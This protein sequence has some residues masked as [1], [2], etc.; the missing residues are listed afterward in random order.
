MDLTATRRY[1]GSLQGTVRSG[2]GRYQYSTYFAYEGEFVNG[3]RHGRGRLLFGQDG[4]DGFLEGNWADGELSGPCVPDG[5]QLVGEWVRGEQTGSATIRITGV[6]ADGG[7]ALPGL[8]ASAAGDAGTPS[9][10]AAVASGAAPTDPVHKAW[11]YSGAWH[12]GT[13]TQLCSAWLIVSGAWLPEPTA[14]EDDESGK[15]SAKPATKSSAKSKGKA[16][17]PPAPSPTQL[18]DGAVLGA[19][20]KGVAVAD[21]APLL[22]STIDERASEWLHDA[23][24]TSAVAAAAQA[25]LTRRAMEQ[26]S[27]GDRWAGHVEAVVWSRPGAALPDLQL[28][29]AWEPE[30][31]LAAAAAEIE[32]KA[33]EARA[34]A[35]KAIEDAEAALGSKKR[36]KPKKGEEEP[37]LARPKLRGDG[38]GCMPWQ[39]PAGAE[40]GR[41][42]KISLASV[43]SGEAVAFSLAGKQT[44]AHEVWLRP[45]EDGRAPLPPLALPAECP[46][47]DLE[48]VVEDCS[49]LLWPSAQLM[50]RLALPIRVYE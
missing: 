16:T 28:V 17:E 34:A 31:R 13:P 14:K 42:A 12:H 38:L 43:A 1:S 46:V 25:E 18:P 7:S 44:L 15:G 41:V 50:P 5:S 30:G 4:K 39:E 22:P 48:L 24:V 11:R 10:A 29:L 33:S 47:G 32:A 49:A 19:G 3:K 20:W 26:W 36:P 8:A 23:G 6:T 40:T 21:E 35:D 27:A 37:H 9:Q 2:F 45:G